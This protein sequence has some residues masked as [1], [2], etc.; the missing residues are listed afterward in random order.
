[1]R[2]LAKRIYL[3]FLVLLVLAGVTTAAI[4]AGGWRMAM[5]DQ[6]Q[7]LATYVAGR[8]MAEAHDRAALSA[9]AIE[10]AGTLDVDVI[11]RDAAGKVVVEDVGQPSWEVPRATVPLRDASGTAVGEVTVSAPRSIHA[12]SHLRP[13]LVI[14]LVLVV[15]GVGTRPL[16]RRIARPLERITE[17]SRRF[18]AGD[19][20]TRVAF[21]EPHD[22][23]YHRLRHRRRGQRWAHH[24][25]GPACPH[26]RDE[27]HDLAHAW[28]DMA[29]RIERLVK[30]QKELLANV[31]HELRSPLTRIRVA[32]EL[33]SA[34]E[35][36]LN[37]VERDLGELERLIE[38]VLATSRLDMTGLPT[39]RER[40]DLAG[41]VRDLAGRALHDPMIRG[42]EVRA[43]APATLEVE[44]DPTLLRRALWNLIENAGKYGAPPI[45]VKAEADGSTVVLSVTDLGEGIPEPERERVLE[46]FYRVDKARTPAAPGA[47]APG[48]GLGLTFARKVA[49]V[50]GGSLGLAPVSPQGLRV[51]L[52]IPR[53]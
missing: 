41:L 16:A 11:V 3:H 1:M 27:L 31:S 38:D 22:F 20:S 40:V 7:R 35:G 25:H 19:L 14:G 28:N 53:S 17:A 12:P 24:T 9:R 50:H 21:T 23:G 29:E 43:E 48:F 52:V 42:K 13:L 15:A 44:G 30:G 34:K 26:R 49:E 32:L 51:S 37:D 36:Y 6:A 5:R 18:G 46:P 2:R 4:V 39:R 47:L 8:L 45:V 33:V 10:A